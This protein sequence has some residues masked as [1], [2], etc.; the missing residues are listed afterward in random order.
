[1]EHVEKVSRTLQQ[2]Q[3]YAKLSKYK[4]R[5][6][7]IDYLGHMIN[8]QSVLADHNK[9]DAMVKWPLHI[10]IKSLRG[11]LNLTEYY[12]K[13]IRNYSFIAAPLKDLLKKNDFRWIEEATDTQTTRFFISFH[14]GV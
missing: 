13:F 3:L 14:C 7:K 9:I 2:Y 4:F 11:F 5:V 10:S 8:A 12:Y 1:M 6:L